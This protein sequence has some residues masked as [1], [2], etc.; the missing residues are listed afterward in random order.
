MTGP[1]EVDKFVV[2]MNN[3]PR[4]LASSLN[5]IRAIAA[6]RFS[7]DDGCVGISLMT[8]IGLV[9]VNKDLEI[10]CHAD[11][12]RRGLTDPIN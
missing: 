12:V 6:A 4:S 9:F 11:A 2:V 8:F 10:I 3:A 1:G 5:E 7:K